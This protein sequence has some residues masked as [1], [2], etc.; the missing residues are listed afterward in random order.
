M[1]TSELKSAL[2]SQDGARD[3][4][5]D[6]YGR[7]GLQRAGGP[8]RFGEVAARDPGGVDGRRDRLVRV[9]V[10]GV[11][12]AGQNGE[13]DGD[14]RSLRISYFDAGRADTVRRALVKLCDAEAVSAR[15]SARCGRFLRRPDNPSS[16]SV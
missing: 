8:D 1:R 13:N 5:A 4:R 3:L 16:N 9:L 14:Q 15:R 2:S 12:A 10:V 6:L 7:D 11:A